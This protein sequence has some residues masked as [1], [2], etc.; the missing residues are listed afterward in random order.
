MSDERAPRDRVRIGDVLVDRV[1]MRDATEALEAFLSSPTPHHIVTVNLDF[2]AIAGRNAAFR[3]AL[4]GADLAVADGMPLVWLSKL[5][6]TPLPERVTGV[7]LVAE[8]C[9]LTAARRGRVFLLGAAPITLQRAAS[10]LERRYPRL[11]LAGMYSP[12]FRRL[13]GEEDRFLVEMVR[14]AKAD[15]LLVA[16]GAPRQDLWIRANL[17]ETGA[18]IAIG[19]G[20]VLDL[21]AGDVDRAPRWM[22]RSGLEWFHRLVSEPDRLWWRYFVNDIPTLARLAVESLAP[23]GAR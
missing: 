2:L 18:K 8:A 9:R 22:Q 15:V 6:R 4:N 1:S 12:P 17:A 21:L 13:D 23:G 5:R 11:R 19:V 16:L 7:D 3:D 14:D 10:S 20:C